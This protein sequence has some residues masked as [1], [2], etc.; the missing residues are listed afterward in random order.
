[1]PSTYKCD[2]L[3]KNLVNKQITLQGWIH[4]I[5]D[6]SN[7]KFILLRD[8]TGI[9]QCIVKKQSKSWKN[10]KDLSS[11]TVIKIKGKLKKAKIKSPEATIKNFEIEITDLELINKAE[12]LPITILEKDITTQLSKRLDYRSLDIRKAK[13][14]AIFKIQSTIINAFRE[15]FYKDNFI[16]IQPPLIIGTS[17][18]GGTELFKAKYFEK[19][20][21][22]AQSPQLYKQ[23]AAISWEK[24]FSTSPVFRAEKHN[25][26]RH[27]NE[28]RQLDIEIAFTDQFSIMKY[29]EEV[30]KHIAK[31]V[32]TEC[33]QEVTLLKLNLKIPKAKYL[34]YKE[35]IILLNKKGI[36]IKYG[37]DLEPEAEKKL[38]EV[39]KDTIVFIHSW[40]NALKP[41]Y[42][43]PIN[44]EI[45][46]GFDAIYGGVE[47]SSGG[48]RVHIPEILIKN[49]KAKKL[50]PKDFKW[51]IDAFRY[52][53]PNHSGWSIGLERITM[54]M[55]NLNN[56]REACLFPRDRDRLTP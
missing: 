56:I 25:T 22:L 50:N 43:W 27:L 2:E 16:E 45:S 15:F 49:L 32:L 3:K 17:T 37:D 46:A 7:I 28:A 30:M 11:E 54:T 51:Y 24:V 21:Y 55:C 48:Q 19:D 14:K 10:F 38:S 47:I 18:E 6:L 26:T 29:L 5:R 39:F 33:K 53:A 36:K 40:P 9:I 4:E 41:F 20:A 34:S 44:K 1:M 8:S 23:L 12:K 31:K 52:G 13:I 42:I 35:T